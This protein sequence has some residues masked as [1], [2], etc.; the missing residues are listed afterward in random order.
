M[1]SSSAR[2]TFELA[3]DITSV[4]SVDTIFKYDHAQ[5]QEILS[6]KPWTKE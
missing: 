1:D 2:A 6:T 4:S 5:Q 3:N